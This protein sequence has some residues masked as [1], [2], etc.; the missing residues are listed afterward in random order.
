MKKLVLSL[1]VIFLL[2]VATIAGASYWFGLQAE[3]IY[4]N[5]LQRFASRQ[6]LTLT[7]HRYQRSWFNATSSAVLSDPKTKATLK[8]DSLLQHGPLP[9]R[10]T[11]ESLRTDPMTI[12]PVQ[13]VVYS[14]LLLNTKSTP[15]Y[16]VS[17]TAVTR[18][19]LNADANTTLQF[20]QGTIQ[21]AKGGT[22]RWQQASANLSYLQQQQQLDG[23][24]DSPM[25][26][27]SGRGKTVILD[28]VR[29]RF[30]LNLE[31]LRSPQNIRMTADV[32]RIQSSQ[33][34]STN[35]QQFFIELQH[36]VNPDNPS[37]NLQA[38]F[39]AATWK[40]RQFGPGQFSF[41][42][43]ALEPLFANTTSMPALPALLEAFKARPP[44]IQAQLQMTGDDGT[45]EGQLDLQL[46]PENITGPGPLA[47]F[48]ALKAD[49]SMTLPR[50]LLEAMMA[51]KL[52]AEILQL[53]QQGK[54]SD[55]STLQQQQILDQAL[56]GRINALLSAKTFVQ[57]ADGRF[58]SHLQ[59][60]HSKLQL[61]DLPL[62]IFE[63]LGKLRGSSMSRGQ[64]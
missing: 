33:S 2:A 35:F 30:R 60:L 17:G 14:R 21:S 58:S 1:L 54:I 32:V 4:T 8:I 56:P 27:F 42:A 12:R 34:A 36:P 23:R 28:T 50:S 40:Q 19:K 53:Q 10:S 46:D 7:S 29:G 26:T 22:I 37:L 43:K 52:R 38:G 49:A 41:S 24:L 13:A 18:V 64:P 55:L 6:Q 57:L 63:L 51:E 61:N 11:F 48:A 31:D 59:L 3:K 44:R 9:M 25:L 47:L 62:N 15:S 39:T 20:D 45:L 16:T 5:G